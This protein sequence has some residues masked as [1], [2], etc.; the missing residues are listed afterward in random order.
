MLELAS[1]RSPAW[2]ITVRHRYKARLKQQMHL[3][4]RFTDQVPQV[5]CDWICGVILYDGVTK[6][7]H[8][9][10]H[11]SPRPRGQYSNFLARIRLDT[12]LVQDTAWI[13]DSP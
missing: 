12:I 5:H 6:E 3:I 9:P 13:L 2:G 4:I 8:R 1:L 7:R 10:K 11:P